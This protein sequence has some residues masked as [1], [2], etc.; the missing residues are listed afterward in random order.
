MAKLWRILVLRG[1]AAITFGL[2]AA[3]RPEMTLPL[4]VVGFGVYLMFESA[5]V[6]YGAVR[7]ARREQRWQALAVYGAFTLAGGVVALRSPDMSAFAVRCL[8]GAWAVAGGVKSAVLAIRFRRELDGEWGLALSAVTSIV[9]GL[10]AVTRPA[11]VLWVGADA[12]VLGV[13]L[14]IAGRGLYACQHRRAHS[15]SLAHHMW[16]TRLF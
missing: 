10:F 14:L 6:L 5:I 8:A 7:C 12:A 11:L 1:L 15:Y 2:P 3:L 16:R 4:F 13:T 9:F